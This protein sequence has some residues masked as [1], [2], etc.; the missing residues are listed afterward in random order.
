[1][2]YIEEYLAYITVERGSSP[3]TIVA[4]RG[5]LERYSTFLKEQRNVSAASEVARDDILAFEEYLRKGGDEKGKRTPRTI[6]RHVSTI[7]GYHRFLLR[8]G[9]VQT[10]P[11]QTVRLPHVPATLPDVLSIDQVCTLLDSMPHDTALQQR[12]AAML[13]V[14][15]GCGLRVSELAGLDCDRVFLDQGYLLV[16]GKGN[17][18]RLAPISGAAARKLG[19]YISAV[20]PQLIPVYAK[21]TP[22]VFLNARGG[23][24]SRQTI[25]KVVSRAGLLIGIKDLHPHT[26]RHS[27]A[28]H[29]LEGG[30]DLR[31]IQEML[32]HSDISTTQ[33][34]THVQTSQLREEYMAAHPRSQ[35]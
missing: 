24:I 5:D 30:A 1:M 34:Y 26:L 19:D 35:G 6:Q 15:Y 33:I 4:Y 12:D 13:E 28:T 22:A 23:R 31:A 7:K 17:K 11:A 2:F 20:R 32:G 8:E 21:P 25:H 10:D 14:L 29:L 3:R 16:L 18:E 27:F 9:L